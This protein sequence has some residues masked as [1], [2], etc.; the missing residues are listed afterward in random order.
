MLVKSTNSGI[1]VKTDGLQDD[2]FNDRRFR[3]AT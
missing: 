2:E 3:E 1:S